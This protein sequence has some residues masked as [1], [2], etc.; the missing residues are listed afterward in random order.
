VAE[1]T[2]QA[3]LLNLTHDP[4]FVRD[5]SDVIAYWNRGAQELY[6]WTDNGIAPG[7]GRPDLP[8]I[9]YDQG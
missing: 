4:I 7:A 2:Q 9:L 3:S 8:G 5:M 6:G 1:R